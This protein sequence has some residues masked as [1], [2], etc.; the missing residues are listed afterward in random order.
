MIITYHH[1][2]DN[3][4]AFLKESVEKTPPKL[5]HEELQ[6]ETKIEIESKSSVGDD[7]SAPL[8]LHFP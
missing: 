3:K 8:P 2:P 7:H 5:G 6:L 1:L 4:S